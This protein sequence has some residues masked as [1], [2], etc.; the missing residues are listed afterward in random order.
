VPVS[1]DFVTGMAHH[2]RHDDHGNAYKSQR[3]YGRPH[4]VAG[5]TYLP[6]GPG[7]PTA[8]TRALTLAFPSLACLPALGH[9]FARGQPVEH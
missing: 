7:T 6:L 9:L 2:E 8:P 5:M 1:A 4:P 3:G